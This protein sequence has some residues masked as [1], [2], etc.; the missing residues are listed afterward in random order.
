MTQPITSSA[1]TNVG[2]SERDVQTLHRL[3]RQYGDIKR[4]VVFGSR[5][6]GNYHAGSD[7]DIAVM[8]PDVSQQSLRRL[9]ADC[10]D[11]DLPYF[12]DIVHAPSLV[13][14]A[15][16]DHIDRVG[17]LLYQADD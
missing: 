2:L 10:E 17:V 9:Q 6:K 5:A 16:K 13:N 8:N 15:L 7:I 1:P 14:T 12:V 11:S 3:L 4:V